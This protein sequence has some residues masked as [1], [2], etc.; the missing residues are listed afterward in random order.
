MKYTIC[1]YD[2]PAAKIDIKGWEWRVYDKIIFKKITGDFY[3]FVLQISEF[4]CEYILCLP[5]G[6]YTG[7]IPSP[8][9][10]K[11]QNK[12]FESPPIYS[13]TIIFGKVTTEDLKKIGD[14]SKELKEKYQ[15]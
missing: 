7:E 1:Y 3:E 12:L 8:E 9:N 14:V 2:N 10:I 4:E 5:I 13:K 11:S 6:Y 15:K